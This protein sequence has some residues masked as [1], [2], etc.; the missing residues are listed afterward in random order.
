MSESQQGGA[1]SHLYKIILVGDA[2]VGK[3]H[4]LSRYTRGSLPVLPKATIGVEF[5]TR[6]VP[7]AVGG[8]VK[9]QACHPAAA[10]AAAAAAAADDAAAD[11][12]A[13]TAASAMNRG[14][15]S[16]TAQAGRWLQHEETKRSK[17]KQEKTKKIMQCII[18]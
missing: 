18:T 16:P 2:T 9:A 6:T 15:C 13:N 10:D 14:A 12:L 17:T 5:V 11:A 8:T 3:T 1:Y 7:L 4:L